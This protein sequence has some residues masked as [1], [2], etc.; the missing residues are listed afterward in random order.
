MIKLKDLLAS[1]S[2]KG[3][4]SQHHP[5]AAFA[6]TQPIEEGPAEDDM[7]SAEKLRHG[8]EDTITLIDKQMIMIDQKLSSFNSPGLKH[9][10]T[11]ALKDGLK[12]QGKFDWK[13]ASRR[14]K[15]YYK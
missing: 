1:S 14:L 13:S 4:I 11:D 5:A 15:Q 9:A 3:H 10:F 7:K 6:P 12:R 8:L 2:Q